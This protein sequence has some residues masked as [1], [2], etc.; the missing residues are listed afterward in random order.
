ME[1]SKGKNFEIYIKNGSDLIAINAG[2]EEISKRK[3][4]I[5]IFS[6]NDVGLNGFDL[7]DIKK[8]TFVINGAGEYEV[9]EDYIRGVYSSIKFN[10]KDYASI[11]YELNLGDVTVAVMSPL[12]DKK[13]LED[14]YNSNGTSNIVIFPII[15]K[16]GLQNGIWSNI[17]KMAENGVIIL[18]DDTKNINKIKKD[19]GKVEEKD[20]KITIKK[21]DLVDETLSLFS[22]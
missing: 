15:S 8:D 18:G 5:S 13:S 16:F 21:R 9:A 6:F 3:P 10:D 12:Q 1:I 11:S 17:N 19:F 14:F 22:L 7:S 4:V 2:R 20:G